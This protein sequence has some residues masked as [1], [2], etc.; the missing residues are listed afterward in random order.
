MTTE[1][2]ME[3]VEGQL[4]RLRWLNHCLIACIVLSLGLWFFMK[5]LGSETAWAQS[6]TKEIRAT[7]FIL[8]DPNGKPCATLGYI[9][10]KG[11]ALLL[12]DKNDVVR[13][14]L[15]LTPK[16]PGL[17]LMDENHNTRVRLRGGLMLM[18]EDESPRAALGILG[19][20]GPQLVLID[21]NKRPRAGIHALKGEPSVWL[22]DQN[23]KPRAALTVTDIG[24]HLS[25][26]DENGKTTWSTP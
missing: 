19:R 8:E 14:T 1:E 15:D 26:I 2:R 4:V 22:R 25:L 10:N 20:Q 5:T 23:G 17:E 13:A 24:P 11:P 3:K 21:Q 12:L 9:E 6:G 16:G 7:K 18:D